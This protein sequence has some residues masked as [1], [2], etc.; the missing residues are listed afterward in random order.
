MEEGQMK[1]NGYDAADVNLERRLSMLLAGDSDA[2]T[3]TKLRSLMEQTEAAIVDAQEAARLAKEAA[4]DPTIIPDVSDARQQMED[5]SLRAG[6]LQTLLTRLQRR[7]AE[8]ADAERLKQW[9]RDFADLKQE[10]D[11]LALEFDADYPVLVNDL[12]DLLTQM[13]ILDGKLSQLHQARPAGV[14]WHLDNPE[15]MARGLD[16]FSRDRPSLLTLLRLHDRTGKQ[17]WPRVQPRDMS[18]FDPQGYADPRASKDW[19]KFAEHDAARAKA[20]SERVQEYYEQ[21]Q[22]KREEQ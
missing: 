16:A 9:Q 8:V 11:H 6:R 20:E 3:A 1:S 18:L 14:K 15:L 17:V 10:R 7:H 12:V 22:R 19:Y 5:A 21:Q 2:L 13:A 4:L